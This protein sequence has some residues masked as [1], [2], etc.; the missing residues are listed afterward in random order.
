MPLICHTLIA[1]IARLVSGEAPDEPVA[2][3]K[4][5]TRRNRIRFHLSHSDNGTGHVFEKRLIES[6][7]A[8]NGKDP[9]TEEEL[10]VEDLI[11]LQTARAVKP[12]PP[13][14][15]S[16]PSLLTAFQ[17][18]WDTL[19][20]EHFTLQQSLKSTKQELSTALY[21]SDAAARVITR[22]TKERDE[23]RDAL[24]KLSVSER[25]PAASQNAA[26]TPHGDAGDA[27]DVD[28]TVLPQAVANKIDETKQRSFNILVCFQPRH[29]NVLP[30]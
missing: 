22:L 5:G 10:T 23:A 13:T 26:S 29:T 11:V 9:I 17:N 6:Y 7:I 15:T 8:D 19:T 12:R 1:L 28:Q 21:N 14:L 2:S 4:S 18:E 16:I 30:D 20:L 27:M 25:R 24:S 3:K